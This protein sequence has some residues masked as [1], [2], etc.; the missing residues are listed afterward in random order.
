MFVLDTFFLF[1]RGDLENHN[2]NTIQMK[3]NMYLLGSG[4]TLF[5]KLY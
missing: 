2:E 1:M 5:A 4:V 3:L